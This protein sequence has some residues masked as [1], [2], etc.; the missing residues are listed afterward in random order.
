MNNEIDSLNASFGI[1][2]QIEFREGPGGLAL[3]ELV[4][5]Q[6]TARIL[7]QGAQLIDWVPRGQAPVIWLSGDARFVDGKSARGGVP[8]CWPWFG[9][10]ATESGYPAHGYARGAPWQVIGSRR[11]Q[12]NAGTG[13]SLR[14]QRSD[15]LHAM[16]P[17]DCDLEIHISVAETLAMEL[18]TRNTGSIA[19]SISEALHT[20]FSVSDVRRI[21]VQGLDGCAYLDKVDDGTRCTQQGPVTFTAE[22]DRIYLHAAGDCLIDDPGLSRRIRIRKQGSA[23]TVVWNPWVDKAARL[24]DMGDDGYLHMVCVESGNVADDTVTIA[25][26]EQHRISVEYA[27]EALP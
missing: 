7:L 5:D 19:V 13:L 24:G 25:A 15:R 4:N 21:A 11:A 20:Y 8:V 14:L 26:G 1:P 22:T 2:G 9:P 10:H 23:S 17:H 3:V 16:W 12:G 27:V 18:V 6:S